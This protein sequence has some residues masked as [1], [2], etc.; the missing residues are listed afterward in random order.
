MIGGKKKSTLALSVGLAIFLLPL[1]LLPV[2]AE[3]TFWDDLFYVGIAY[4]SDSVPIV[5]N[6]YFHIHATALIMRFTADPLM[7]PKIL[8]CLSLG[9]AAATL[10]WASLRGAQST[11]AACSSIVIGLTLLVLQPSLLE[12][13][14]LNFVDITLMPLMLLPVVLLHTAIQA[15]FDVSRATWLAIGLLVFC[16]LKT[17]EPAVVLVGL[18]I[19]PAFTAA[20]PDRWR[21]LARSIGFFVAGLLLAQAGLCLVDW[22]RLDNPWFSLDLQNWRTLFAYNVGNPGFKDQPQTFFTIMFSSEFAPLFVAYCLSVAFFWGKVATIG[23]ARFLLYLLPVLF[24]G[25]QSVLD[26]AQSSHALARYIPPILPLTAFIVTQ[27]YLGMIDAY[28]RTGRARRLFLVVSLGTLATVLLAAYGLYRSL[29]TLHAVELQAALLLAAILVAASAALTNERSLCLAATVAL[30]IGGAAV[31]A[32]T[33]AT[34]LL[35]GELRTLSEGRFAD[36]QNV[37]A[38][39]EVSTPDELVFSQDAQGAQRRYVPRYLASLYRR[40]TFDKHRIHINE[41]PRDGEGNVYI[42]SARSTAAADV[43]ARGIGAKIATPNLV[44]IRCLSR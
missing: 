36:L 41:R 19:L 35:S 1:C 37:L 38:M 17:K 27:A 20:P 32:R 39:L 16:A 22:V 2:A 30:I 43:C 29:A 42:L 12:S 33:P 5:L 8:W 23:R 18:P 40:Q 28:C 7:A 26:L 14:G 9:L 3:P 4:T 34:R 31:A 24:L 44:G 10:G 13:V 6:R 11:F 21:S 25:L 15:S